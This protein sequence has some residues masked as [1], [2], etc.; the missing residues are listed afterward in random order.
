M[1]VFF[2]YYYLFYSKFR[3]DDDPSFSMITIMSILEYLFFISIIDLIVTI[4]YCITIST[5]I[6]ILIFILIY[7]INYLIYIKSLQIKKII[8]QKPKFFGSH[9][10]SKLITIISTILIVLFYLRLSTYSADIYNNCK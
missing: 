1:K 4:V 8:K 5:L 6:S 10:I 2:Y 9:K 7:F 3:H